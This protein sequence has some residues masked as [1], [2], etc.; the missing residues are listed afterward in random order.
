MRN[1]R[2]HAAL[3]GITTEERN[4]H[5]GRF[6]PQPIALT[7]RQVSDRAKITLPSNSKRKEKKNEYVLDPSE[8]TLLSNTA[9]KAFAPKVVLDPSKI[10]LLSN[11]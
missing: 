5:S 6:Q 9:L 8:I 11:R 7:V 1:F 3:G 10:T 2:K 4:S